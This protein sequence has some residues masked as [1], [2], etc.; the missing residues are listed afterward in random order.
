[1]ARGRFDRCHAINSRTQQTRACG[2]GKAYSSVAIMSSARKPRGRIQSTRDDRHGVDTDTHCPRRARH[3]TQATSAA[4]EAATSNHTAIKLRANMCVQD[5]QWHTRATPQVR[6]IHCTAPEVAAAARSSR[7]NASGMYARSRVLSAVVPKR[8]SAS[9]KARTS[10]STLASSAATCLSL[11]SRRSAQSHSFMR[12][13]AQAPKTSVHFGQLWM[14]SP[15]I[16]GRMFRDCAL[17]PISSS[18]SHLT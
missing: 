5:Y 18:V 11:P 9:P 8:P 13:T 10:A 3:E 16:D 1:M 14:S 6:N 15:Y 17:R 7:R 12:Q 4:P 2:R